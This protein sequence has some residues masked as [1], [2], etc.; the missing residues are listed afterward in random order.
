MMSGMQMQMIARGFLVYQLTGSAKIVGLVSAAGALPLLG[1]ALFGGAIADR[2]DRKRII[3]IGQGVSTAL[4]L[5]VAVSITTET[6][7]WY[8]LLGTSLLQGVM[9]SFLTPARQ[10][11]IPELV[12]RRMLSNAMALNGAGFS[13]TILVAPTVGGLL[14]ALIGPEGVYYIIAALGLTAVTLTNP[15][16]STSRR[17]RDTRS[18]I[19]DDIKAGLSY[20][21]GNHLV[22]VLLLVG[23]V[24]VLLAMPFK[25][26]LPA[27]VADVYHR[28]A[29]AFGLLISMLGLGSLAGSLAFA[30]LG[31]WRRGL[32]L[33]A[34]GMASG[35]ALLLVA[36]VPLY[37]PAIGIMVL[38]GL[39]D[40][41]RRVLILVLIMEQV[42][43]RYQG[44]VMSV[45]AMTFGLMPL[46][47]LPAGL[48]MDAWGGRTAALILG[49]AMLTTTTLVLVTQKRLRDLQ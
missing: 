9:W 27:F 2:M 3:Q 4:A 22:L 38:L 20:I 18:P 28:E 1:L 19:L 42:E 10:A 39:G 36:A 15:I 26:L 7:T 33:I 29:E 11:I 44:R 48:A 49:A 31:R 8:H 37:Y 14:Y 30:S 34:G 40:A 24:T 23:V 6:L 21:W 46:G 5:F 45:Y 12:G 43:D 41:G 13:I 47:I 16:S 35:I 32:M 25:F 17:G